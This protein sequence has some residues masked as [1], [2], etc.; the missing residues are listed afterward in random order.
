MAQY[1]VS[2]SE[3]RGAQYVDPQSK[4]TWSKPAAYCVD[5]DKCGTPTHIKNQ[6]DFTYNSRISCAAPQVALQYALKGL[7]KI[8]SEIGSPEANTAS[9]IDFLTTSATN[10]G[11]TVSIAQDI[12]Q[13]LL[14]AI[15]PG[16]T[17]TLQNRSKS[18]VDDSLDSIGATTKYLFQVAR[19]IIYTRNDNCGELAGTIVSGSYSLSIVD[20]VTCRPILRVQR[21]AS[22]F[23]SVVG[24]ATNFTT[25][26]DD[27][28]A[29]T[30]D[31]AFLNGYPF[32]F[33]CESGPDSTFNFPLPAGASGTFGV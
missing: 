5:L 26:N 27:I 17:L 29:I 18:F 25:A 7:S 6:H 20:P 3:D 31:F 2:V 14:T 33:N 24:Y 4:S 12:F 30:S 28:L 10:G 16:T 9:L 8:G 15:A 22:I 1:N 21:S 13:P 23:V 19:P 32:S 11:A